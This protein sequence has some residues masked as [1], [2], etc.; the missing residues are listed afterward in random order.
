MRG[1]LK[2]KK[3]EKATKKGN[4]GAFCI[5]CSNQALGVILNRIHCNLQLKGGLYV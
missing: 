1:G 2:P 5:F 4:S 3:K